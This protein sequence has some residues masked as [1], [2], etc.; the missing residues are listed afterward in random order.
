MTQAAT[1]TIVRQI[2][3]IFDGDSIAEAAA[4]VSS[5]LCETRADAA[6]LFADRRTTAGCALVTASAST[7]AH[8]VLQ[9]MIVGRFR[10]ALSA[11][12]A[13]STIAAGARY[14]AGA[15]ATGEE[16][17]LAITAQVPPASAEPER[18]DD[19]QSHPK[20]RTN[21]AAP[22]RMTVIGAVMD[23]AGKPI[24]R[25][26]VD[27]V[28]RP[29]VPYMAVVEK[30]DAYKLL[31]KGA[32]GDDGRFQFDI[33]PTSSARYYDVYALTAAPGYGLS[34]TV[35]NPDD[36]DPF[37]LIRFRPEQPI[38]I[39]M[40]DINAQPA[41]SVEVR[42]A[43]IWHRYT[44]IRHRYT[45][46]PINGVYFWNLPP[47]GV[48]VWPAPLHTDDRGRF[49]LAGLA[50]GDEVLL[51]AQDRRFARAGLRLQADDRQGPRDVTLLLRPATIIEGQVLAADSGQP[52]PHATIVVTA[53]EGRLGG[54]FATRFRADSQGRFEANPSPGDYFHLTA[55]PTNGEPYLPPPVE[56]AWTKGAVRK[57][58]DIPLP[59][60][61][62][63]RGKVTALS[64]STPLSGASVQF[65]SMSPR[66]RNQG[67]SNSIVASKDDG[68]FQL[69]VPPGKGHL[70]I[71]GP[72]VDFILESI[73][74]RTLLDGQPGGRRNYAHKILAYEFQAGAPAQ[75]IDAALRRANTARGRVVGPE[76]QTVKEARILS[77]LHIEH[78]RPQWRG[79]FKRQT[80]RDGAFEL[81]GLDPEKPVPV[82]FLDAVNQWGAAVELAGKQSGQET[83][84]HLQPCG[85]ATA[86]FVG[87]DGRPLAP[88]DVRRLSLFE[89]LVT[90][91]P[92]A[93]TRDKNEQSQLAADALS[94]ELIDRNHYA[95][96]PLTDAAGRIT[97]P[98]LI[99]GARYRISDKSTRSV[100]GKG[101]QIRK[102]FTVKPAEKLDLGD[103]L[104]EK[105]SR[106]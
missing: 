86:R 97:L 48:R 28:G 3:S 13:L 19:D 78:Y 6:L 66:D 69:V 64:S 54:G 36:P 20:A 2:E 27:V 98:V 105:P 4:S 17:P 77:R 90:P 88:L 34:W 37:V 102:D 33:V 68:S 57:H 7:L 42:V 58:L 8:H 55:Y 95:D 84:I 23:P 67:R 79:D 39:R 104:I 47:E 83:T 16:P 46:G 35:L 9:S 5:K 49:V 93:M 65:L 51:D 25:V 106:P 80:T 32:T 30:F 43:S 62:L 41:A 99:P 63:I 12:L 53:R 100:D 11:A 45:S 15:I 73:G 1:R 71:F 74:D 91:G 29:R 44:G 75:T 92:H 22:G 85:Q 61:V 26:P 21:N 60:G 101:V 103:V 52:I 40:V 70:L 18:R 38:R 31:G 56:F 96:P 10:F 89:I 59:R 87:P 76:G 72:T 81:H 50:V 94:V 24:A 82:Y 14:L